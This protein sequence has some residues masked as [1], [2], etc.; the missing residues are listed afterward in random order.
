[1]ILAVS[2]RWNLYRYLVARWL[3]QRVAR[4][5]ARLDA[6]ARTSGVAANDQHDKARLRLEV[7]KRCPVLTDKGF[8]SREK[9]GCGCYMPAKVQKPSATCPQGRW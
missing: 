2:K 9:G 6:I 4:I 1:M 7:C 5:A 8:C 3:L